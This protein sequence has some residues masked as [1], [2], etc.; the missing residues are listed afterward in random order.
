M[1]NLNRWSAFQETIGPTERVG[2][3]FFSLRYSYADTLMPAMTRY[4]AILY[5][6]LPQCNVLT[7]TLVLCFCLGASLPSCASGSFYDATF[8]R[9]SQRR[10]GDVTESLMCVW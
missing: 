8:F 6:L 3:K 7:K 10:W 9:A 2:M 1:S 4:G 5:F